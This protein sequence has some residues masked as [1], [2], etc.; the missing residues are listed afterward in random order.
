[1]M[2]LNQS[3]P[4]IFLQRLGQRNRLHFI[5]IKRA[6]DMFF[7]FD[8]SLD[9]TLAPVSSRNLKPFHLAGLWL[10]VIAMA[11]PG[12]FSNYTERN[13]R[14]GMALGREKHGC[15]WR[16]G[17]RRQQRQNLRRRNAGRSRYKPRGQLTLFVSGNQPRPERNNAHWPKV[18]SSAIT[19][20]QPSVPNLMGL[21]ISTSKRENSKWI[22]LLVIAR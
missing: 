22:Q 19:A 6:V 1:M 20:R 8:G 21:F 7:H 18:K 12:L 16:P 13:K 11:A 10:A 15:R 14:V 4:P 2:G 5:R 3:I 17:L 9:E